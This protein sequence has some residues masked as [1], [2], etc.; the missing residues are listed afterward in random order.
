ME[1]KLI[2]EALKQAINELQYEK[3]QQERNGLAKAAL[4]FVDALEAKVN[5]AERSSDKCH[6]QNVSC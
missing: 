3:W 1:P 4:N 6:I 2:I 5:D